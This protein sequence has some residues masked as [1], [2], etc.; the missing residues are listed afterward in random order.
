[1][2]S[3]E[4]LLNDLE[5]RETDLNGVEISDYEIE[6]RLQCFLNGFELAEKIHKKAIS[7][8]EKELKEYHE[9]QIL[10]AGIKREKGQPFWKG[11]KH[12]QDTKDKI[13]K[14]LK[15]RYKG[16]KYKRRAKLK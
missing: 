11:R 14:R 3:F 5:F 8:L 16:M 6:M 4:E 15:D 9:R 2:K 10:N 13:S 1:M 7:N 12:T